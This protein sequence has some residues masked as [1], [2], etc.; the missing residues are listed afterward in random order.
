MY[1]GLPLHLIRELCLTFYNFRE[2]VIKFI[3][4]R[5]LTN[6]MNQRFPD[7]TAE[8]VRDSDHSFKKC[9]ICRED[10]EQAKKLPCNHLFHFHCL[11]TW[12]ETRQT[13][14]TCRAEISV[15]RP[16]PVPTPVL[17]VDRAAAEGKQTNTT[18]QEDNTP[19]SPAFNQ[20]QS[21]PKSGQALGQ[22]L[23]QIQ[24]QGQGYLA[25]LNSFPITSP[26]SHGLFMTST[27][28]PIVPQS[29]SL[30]QQQTLLLQQH[31]DVLQRQLAQLEQ[32]YHAHLNFQENFQQT[33]GQEKPEEEGKSV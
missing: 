10:L 19:V 33:T 8:E 18:H 11:R 28:I 25:P 26:L 15:N 1:Y 13:C 2:R 23:G 20:G 21:L 31:I 32:L 24:V 22:A 16:L 29:L 7:A 12:L 14:P 6:N 5:R 27:P 3:Q 9:I 30:C 4:Y 17:P